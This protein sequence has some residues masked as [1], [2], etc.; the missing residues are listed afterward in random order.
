MTC[1][2]QRPTG[3]GRTPGE[4]GDTEWSATPMMTLPFMKAFDIILAGTS[5]FCMERLA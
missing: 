5:A 1:L 3:S 2:G 4:A